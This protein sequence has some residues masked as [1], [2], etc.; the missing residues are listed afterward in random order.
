MAQF[1]TLVN[2]KLVSIMQK[3][4]F[5][6]QSKLPQTQGVVTMLLSN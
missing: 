1:W 5:E 3:L 2:P 4:G 6:L